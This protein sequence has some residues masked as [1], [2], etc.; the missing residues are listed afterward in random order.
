MAEEE[1]LSTKNVS[2]LS[3]YELRQE[4]TR[5]G[6]MDLPEEMVSHKSLLCRLI[7]E[8]VADEAAVAER[9]VA[10]AEKKN[11]DEREAARLLREQRKAE[12]IAR[13]EARRNDPTYFKQ[14][15]ELNVAPAQIE[16]KDANGKIEEDDD[17]DSDEVV[18]NDDPFRSYKAKA[19]PKIMVR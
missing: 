8:L 18:G 16:E 7:T 5:R 19:R 2:K 10:L 17:G 9:A 1:P 3:T 15:Q 13:S 12:A 11:S 6:K 14:K 4:L